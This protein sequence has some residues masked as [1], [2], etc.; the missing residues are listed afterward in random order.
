MRSLLELEDQA[1]F[2]AF[3]EKSVTLTRQ[4]AGV[5]AAEKGFGGNSGV[6]D[7]DGDEGVNV[8]AW[9]AAAGW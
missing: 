4:R 8:D 1:V 6:V 9:F 7:K 3:V 5:A 2:D